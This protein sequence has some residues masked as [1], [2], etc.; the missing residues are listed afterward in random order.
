ML[1]AVEVL[2]QVQVEQD[3][4]VAVTEQRIVLEVLLQITQEVVVVVA[5]V[6]MMVEQEVRVLSLSVTKQ[7]VLT[8][9]L[10]PQL[11]ER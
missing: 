3:K 4:L 7:M 11:V 10:I 5:K 2:G 8:V 6:V 9:F 1:V